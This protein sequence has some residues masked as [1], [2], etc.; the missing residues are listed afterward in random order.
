MKRFLFA[1][2]LCG[3]AS[4]AS[5]QV[6]VTPLN[7]FVWDQAAP[8]LAS[9]NGYTYKYYDGA[10]AGVAFAGVVCAGAASPFT[11]QVGIPALTPG[12]H[13]AFTISASNA[14]GESAKAPVPAFALIVVPVTPSNIRIQ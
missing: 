1:L 11:C 4:T 14:A 7:K 12:V 9:A 5:A 10:A 2:L 13:N 8:D 6:P 3:I